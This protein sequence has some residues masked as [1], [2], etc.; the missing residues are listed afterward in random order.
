MVELRRKDSLGWHIAVLAR[1]MAGQLDAELKK[2]DLKIAYWPTLFLLWE[3]EGLSQTELAEAC[4][5]EHYTTT[6]VLDK[7]EKLGLLVR[8]PDPDSRRTFRIYLTRKGHLLEEPLTRAAQRVN[9]KYLGRLPKAEQEQLLHLL[10]S[11][12]EETSF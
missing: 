7:L 3:Q 12:N 4:H 10:Q 8:R 11:L 2:H 6:R 9:H 5:T 1:K